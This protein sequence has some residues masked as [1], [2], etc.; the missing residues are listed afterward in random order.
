M[1]EPIPDGPAAGKVMPR[2]VIDRL[3]DEYYE[4]RGWDQRGIPSRAKVAEMGLD[5]V[6]GVIAPLRS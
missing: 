1:E 5:F 6:E 4:L 3:L 2:E